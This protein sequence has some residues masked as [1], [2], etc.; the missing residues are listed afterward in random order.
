MDQRLETAGRPLE[1][2]HVITSLNVGGAEAMLFKVVTSMDPARFKPRVLALSDMGTYGGRLQ[3]HGVEVITLNMRPN[4]PDPRALEGL[5]RAL[6]E[7]P[8]DILQGWMYHGNLAALLGGK[9][10]GAPHIVWN[11]RSADLDL[12][13]YSRALRVVVAVHG[14]FARLPEAIVVNSWA[15][16]RSHT[17]NGHR[18]SRWKVI[19]NGFDLEVFKPA[20]K[21]RQMLRETL[22]IPD[23]IPLIG[24]VARHDPMKDHRTF[25]HAS[26]ALLDAGVD[27]RF[28]LVGPGYTV[29]NP[30]FAKLV[31][32]LQLKDHVQLL[33]ERHDIPNVLAGLDVF[34][35]A[36]LSEGFPNVVGEAM[37]TGVPCVVTDVGDSAAIV[38]STGLVVPPG[39]PKALARALQELAENADER[40]RQGLAARARIESLYG[41]PAVVKQ[42]EDLYE[43]LATKCA[44]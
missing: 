15:G 28:A 26:R 44:A 4:R 2:T 16:Y 38:G 34:C 30:S 12:N 3:A 8:P 29:E 7:N 24:M 33:G 37:A 25:L 11:V 6:R 27:A 35:L 14:W 20:P 18:A 13:R 23:G 17:A 21:A 32:E 10:T 19:P 41:L 1:I 43:E 31:A 36:S 39:D 5:L 42:Y 22:E 40:G 9:L